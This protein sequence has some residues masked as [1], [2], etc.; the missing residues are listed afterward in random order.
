MSWFAL[1][2]SAVFE[3]IWATALGASDGFTHLAPSLVFAVGL[4]ISMVAL[5]WAARSIPIGTA[6]AVWVGIGAAL[7]VGYALVTGTEGF[8]VGK[9]VCILGIIAAVV[10]LKLVPSRPTTENVSCCRDRSP[11][12]GGRSARRPRP[13]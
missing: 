6:Y 2:I 4:I 10:G 5:G 7:T 1:V 3:A 11:T 9:L 13:W 8:S 12:A